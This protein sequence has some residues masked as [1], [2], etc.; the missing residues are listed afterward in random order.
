[1]WRKYGDGVRLFW[2]WRI[3]VAC[4]QVAFDSSASE[5]VV[6]DAAF[7]SAVATE[8]DDRLY[9]ELTNSLF[10]CDWNTGTMRALRL[11]GPGAARTWD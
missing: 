5:V 9:P 11:G 10:A 7:A 4:C 2:R 1:M 3:P 8:P 6:A